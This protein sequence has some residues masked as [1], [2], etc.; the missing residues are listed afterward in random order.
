MKRLFHFIISI[1]QTFK[2][3]LIHTTLTI[4]GF[5]PGEQTPLRM[6][7]KQ[8]KA[9][10]VWDQVLPSDQA[11]GV[12]GRAGDGGNGDREEKKAEKSPWGNLP[13]CGKK[14]ESPLLLIST[15]N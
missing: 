7:V 5:L 10:V 4:H 6:R 3:V 8:L 13:H 9:G 15:G 14:P 11:D 2:L 12:L 1:M